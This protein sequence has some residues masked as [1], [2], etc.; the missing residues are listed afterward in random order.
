M[1]HE[2]KNIDSLSKEQPV[3]TEAES[4]KSARSEFL[5]EHPEKAGVHGEKP[6]VT[7]RFIK[8]MN[9]SQFRSQIIFLLRTE[10]TCKDT[11]CMCSGTRALLW[12]FFLN[13]TKPDLLSLTAAVEPSGGVAQP[14]CNCCLRER[15]QSPLTPE[16]GETW[17][18][19]QHLRASSEAV[20]Y[21]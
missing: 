1:I 3:R 2:E 17:A 14:W 5:L 16:W 18:L 12:S 8:I 21:I 4:R 6:E 9:P 19:N 15:P 20:V 13:F 7:P 10:L 11:D